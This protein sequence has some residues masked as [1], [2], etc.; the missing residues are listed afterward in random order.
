MHINLYSRKQRWKVVLFILALGIIAASLA[1]SNLIVNKIRTE[2]R[3][4]IELWAEAIQNKAKLVRY[5]S[6]LFDKLRKGEQEKVELMA[7]AWKVLAD[8]VIL[9]DY[10]FITDVIGSN[11]TVPVII[12]D[13]NSN[14]MFSRNLD[15][16]RSSDPEYLREQLKIMKAVYEPIEFPISTSGKQ[17]L[18]YRDSKLFSE[19]QRVMKD[20]IRSFISEVVV[21]SASVPVIYT[22]E[23]QDEVINFGNIDSTQIKN[24]DFVSRRIAEMRS[25]NDPI[26]VD[27]GDGTNHY[28]FYEDSLLLTQL[29]YYPYVVLFFISIFLLISYLLFSTFRKA[30]QNQV[31]VGMAKETA[32]QLGTPLSSLVAWVEILRE[33]SGQD[34]MVKELEKDVKRLE[35]ITERFSKIGS[36]SQLIAENMEVMLEQS[37]QYLKGRVSQKVKFA[38]HIEG[39]DE[40]FALINKPLFEWVIENL[41]KNAVDAMAGQGHIDLT[42]RRKGS[43]VQLDVKDTG[44]GIPS[45]KQKTI[46]EPGYTTKK[47]GWGLGLSL[48][49]RIIENYH[50]GKIFVH[51]SDLHK[52]TTFRI[53][54]KSG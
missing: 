38:I 17:Y 3:K 1:Y 46:F 23:D 21:N 24:P 40:V 50:K 44:K 14:T 18:Y 47:T 34:E 16:L 12:V 29:K 8:P 25:Q 33:K 20:L 36:Q 53:I 13:E 11:T 4:K 27:L 10:T 48:V 51:Q 49:K 54:L 15:S 31:W 6:E 35:T 45:S 43:V 22:D 19:L 52:G 32:H 5:T 9:D 41:C 2:E 7:K 26:S 42:V 28:I 30:E 37:I 39:D